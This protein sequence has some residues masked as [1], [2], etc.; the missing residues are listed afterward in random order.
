MSEAS[1]VLEEFEVLL[2]ELIN[3]AHRGDEQ[4]IHN[5]D[6]VKQWLNDN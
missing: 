5:L 1:I 6:I 2:R 4:A 3:K